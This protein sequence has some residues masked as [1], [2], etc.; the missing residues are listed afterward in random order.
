MYRS[1]SNGTSSNLPA[2]CRTDGK[3]YNRMVR[4]VQIHLSIEIRLG[5]KVEEHPAANSCLMRVE[6]RVAPNSPAQPLALQR[7]ADVEF[8]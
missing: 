5:K 2:G 7:D 4:L 1:G 6:K 8:F 3:S